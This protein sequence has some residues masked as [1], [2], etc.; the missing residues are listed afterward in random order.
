MRNRKS[1]LWSACCAAAI[2]LGFSAS[3]N[4]GVWLDVEGKDIGELSH[5]I[6]RIQELNELSGTN[7][8]MGIRLN[9]SWSE[10]PMGSPTWSPTE[11]GRLQYDFTELEGYLD[12]VDA[13]GLKV[14]L[15]ISDKYWNFQ[16]RNVGVDGDTSDDK[17]Y[18]GAND[19]NVFFG[20]GSLPALFTRESKM[21]R[22]NW[23]G[24]AHGVQPE[25][26]NDE[27]VQPY[28]NVAD[29]PYLQKESC[30][31]KTSSNT[32][33]IL[34]DKFEK[35]TYSCTT[36]DPTSSFRFA[37]VGSNSNSR[38][39]RKYG[40]TRWNPKIG[41]AVIGTAESASIGSTKGH[42]F[43]FWEDLA[44]EI[45]SHPALYA[46]VTPESSL[47]GIT[48]NKAQLKAVGY[49]GADEYYLWQIAQAKKIADVFAG[50][51]VIS[52]INWIS[53][54]HDTSTAGGIDDSIDT[55][56]YSVETFETSFDT[57]QNRIGDAFETLNSGA[58]APLYGWWAQD[59]RLDKSLETDDGVE[60]RNVRTSYEHLVYPQFNKI[61]DSSLKFTMITGDTLKNSVFNSPANYAQEL[62]ELANSYEVGHLVFLDENIVKVGY[63]DKEYAASE[64]VSLINSVTN[65]NRYSFLN[66]FDPVITFSFVQSWVNYDEDKGPGWR[67]KARKIVVKL[68]EKISD[69]SA[70][71]VSNLFTVT[72]GFGSEIKNVRLKD[73]VTCNEADEFKV[74][75][76][77]KWD[78]IGDGTKNNFEPG[79]VVS[80]SYSGT[81]DINIVGE[82]GAVLE[83]FSGSVSIY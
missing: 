10:I 12:E 47:A 61:Q 83:T 71:G 24:T 27:D 40:A 4:A 31:N 46:V 56:K 77:T 23:K 63:A 26:Y 34:N 70:Q 72:V 73:E 36:D 54:L 33:E 25:D 60:L 75:L 51:P 78:M 62:A 22:G 29:L 65:K 58:D 68:E 64:V 55:S 11:N 32:K 2:S 59:L 15:T 66:T 3:S 81:E 37:V 35:G 49:K 53:E 41:G 50:V 19:D 76:T 28:L 42:W 7:P 69:C 80:I 5:R 9:L 8:W 16:M 1:S 67:D 44:E 14:I 48:H 30:L 17:Y 38:A 57:Y 45:K 74:F 79:D 52:S 13:A 20:G 21:G 43:N 18:Y 39:S 6:E 82:S